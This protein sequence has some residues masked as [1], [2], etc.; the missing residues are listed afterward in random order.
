MD[1]LQQVLGR[2][3]NEQSVEGCAEVIQR[4]GGGSDPG[5]FEHR[6]AGRQEERDDRGQELPRKGVDE[7]PDALDC[8]LGLLGSEYVLRS[9][10]LRCWSLVCH[11][12]W[13]LVDSDSVEPDQER[14]ER[15]EQTE[16]RQRRRPD[17]MDRENALIH[18]RVR[19]ELAGLPGI[20]HGHLT[21]GATLLAKD[22]LLE[23]YPTSS[24]QIVTAEYLRDLVENAAAHG[25]ARLPCAFQSL[26]QLRE[27]AGQR[28]G[29]PPKLDGKHECYRKE[30]NAPP[31]EQRR[32]A[33]GRPTEREARVTEEAG[34]FKR[35]VGA[36]ASYGW[37]YGSGSVPD[38]DRD[39]PGAVSRRAA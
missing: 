35:H 26:P 18:Q 32:E 10:L 23:L 6:K 34:E 24:G 38:G 25:L 12:R 19:E 27:F 4:P 1:A 21:L 39:L 3:A 20:E 37:V 9:L 8:L 22:G 30:G 2:A 36:S 31:E 17:A 7:V 13:G 16:G 5:A 14:E 15:S 33:P 29:H 28:M 11:R